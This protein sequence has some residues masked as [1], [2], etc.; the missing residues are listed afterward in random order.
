MAMRESGVELKVKGRDKFSAELKAAN[1]D[2][3]QNQAEMN[4]LTAQYGKGSQDKQSLQERKTLLQ[5]RLQTQKEKTLLLRQRYE[6][7]KAAGYT[8][9]QLAAE[10]RGITASEAQEL[11]LQRQ[12][13][14]TNDALREQA[15][16]AEEAGAALE[17]T[18]SKASS[19][20]DKLGSAGDKLTKFGK[21]TRAVSAAA[22]AAG[23][24]LVKNAMELEDKMYTVAT[25]P[26]V[27]AA[28]IPQYTEAILEA[29]NATGIAATELAEAQYTAI[30]S[31]VAAEKSVEFVKLAAMAAKA[32]LTDTQTVVD[33]ATS[34]LNAWGDSAGGVEHVLDVMTTAQNLG[35]VTI[36]EFAS[37]I[38]TL[39]GIAPQGNM[40]LEESAAAIAALTK[41]G[42]DAATATTGLR[43]ILT[44]VIKPSSEAAKVA[45]KLGIEFSAAGFEAKGL[46]GFLA[47]V[48]AKTQG[49]TEIL[50]QLFGNVR[51]LSQVM[52]LG[53]AAAKDY[54]ST[55][56]E[57][58]SAAGTMREAFET[59]TGSRM[60]QLSKSMNALKNSG[61]E[62]AQNLTPAVD[63]VTSLANGAAEFIGNMSESQQAVATGG[64]VAV[65][66]L[67]P[68]S[69]ALGN[70]LKLSK[71][72]AAAMSGPGGWIALGVTGAAALG[73]A[74]INATT[75]R[76]RTDQIVTQNLANLEI[77]IDPESGPNITRAINAAVEAARKDYYA[78]VHVQAFVDDTQEQMD[79]ILEDGKVTQAEY[80]AATKWVRDNVKPDIEAA[81][82]EAS[83]LWKEAYN[84]ALGNGA[85]KAEAREQ[86]DTAAAPLREA[87]AELE[88]L[89]GSYNELLKTVQKKGVDASQE[90]LAEM[91]A[92]LEEMKRVKLEIAE[93]QGDLS[94]AARNAKG[95]AQNGATD[96]ATQQAAAAAVET[97]YKLYEEAASEWAEEAIAANNEVVASTEKGSAE[98]EAAM[99]ERAAIEEKILAESKENNRRRTEELSKNFQS[100]ADANEDLAQSVGEVAQASDLFTYAPMMKNWIDNLPE[101]WGVPEISKALEGMDGGAFGQAFALVMGKSLSQAYK[102][103]P[104][105][106]KWFTEGGLMDQ[107]MVA[108]SEYIKEKTGEMDESPLLGVLQGWADQGIDISSLDV[109]AMSDDLMNAMKLMVLNMEGDDALGSEM[110]QK[111]T[112]SLTNE[113]SLQPVVDS[114]AEASARIGAA[115]NVGGGDGGIAGLMGEM[116]GSI[117]ANGAKVLADASSFMAQLNAILGAGLAFPTIPGGS[118]AGSGSGTGGTTTITG[119]GNTTVNIGTANLGSRANANAL[120]SA[121]SAQ[122]KRN[123][124]GTGIMG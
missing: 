39:T 87:A 63:T 26:G 44:S 8:D 110:W 34:V 37:S 12:I 4:K 31:G 94:P 117:S 119:S 59:R 18:G 32:G 3:K 91:S 5:D 7:H 88:S 42:V 100:V 52:L 83:R 92:I 43:A 103:D 15:S 50:G 109:S 77:Q 29:S 40:S 24:M 82:K 1:N 10:L 108:A 89:M 2:L 30:S 17:G 81:K 13:D 21:Q 98:Y 11:S 102:E 66:A 72:V 74:L 28:E 64:L 79:K 124:R 60:Q 45:K 68:V 85:T 20:A 116:Q 99:A 111:L 33:G 35:K 78:E 27:T 115:F 80:N 22:V 113:E 73:A 122:Q 58:S 57:M 104:A 101:D 123:L 93:L 55:L 114:A 61:M 106:M 25:L 97:E 118:G 6:A 67:S 46:T 23:T 49:D 121:I 14:E 19:L 70:I 62:I 90:E 75:D 107:V 51:G 76:R 16:A 96:A 84:A 120:L 95:A 36:G 9:E 47:D 112:E 69:T 105:I 41:N 54:A 71:L 56:N 65:A 53:G 86:A 38:G 48:M